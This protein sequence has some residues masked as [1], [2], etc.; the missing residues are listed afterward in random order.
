MKEFDAILNEYGIFGYDSISKPILAALVSKEPILLVGEHGTGKT[1]LAE[2]LSIALGVS[3]AEDKKEFNA[4]DASKSLFEDVIGFPNPNALKNGKLEYIESEMTIWNKKF[5]LIDEI[6]RANPSMQNKWLEIIRSRRV[7]GVNIPN[8]QY[9]F[10][11]M[12]PIG[13]LGVNP[14]DLALADRFSLIV[15]VPSSFGRDDLSKIINSNKSCGESSSKELFDLISAIDKISK[16]LKP[17]NNNI[18]DNFIMDFSYKLE[19][20]GLMFSPRRA[21][22]LKKNLSIFF[23]IDLYKGSINPK[24]IVTN[25]IMAAKYSWNYLVADEE[26]YFDK[27]VEAVNFATKEIKNASVKTE[28]IFKQYQQKSLNK[29]LRYI[30]T[31]PTPDP[32]TDDDD[33]DGDLVTMAKLVGSGLE[34]FTVGFYEMVIKGNSN[35]KSKLKINN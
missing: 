2:K 19:E 23:A 7:M 4:Y 26:H 33:D 22:M 18:I 17:S 29:N 30:K 3:V 28:K 9:I 13:Y 1:L 35:W 25:L 14:L 12:N 5:I 31:Q 15:S 11:A 16:N 27:L 20:L 10:S 32:I 21:A 6:S 34:L 8:L 24:E